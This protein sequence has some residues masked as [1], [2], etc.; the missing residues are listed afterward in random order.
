[1]LPKTKKRYEVKSFADLK[2]IPKYKYDVN[3]AFTPLKE[4]LDHYYLTPEVQCGL[5]GCHQW[6]NDGLIVELENGDITNVGHICGAAF[7]DKFLKAHKEYTDKILRP[8]AINDIYEAKNYLAPVALKLSAI[9]DELTAIVHRRVAFKKSF[10]AIS[11]ELTRRLNTGNLRVFESIQRSIVEINEM[12]AMNPYQNK[13]QLAFKE[14]DLGVLRGLVVFSGDIYQ[15]YVINLVRSTHDLINFEISQSVSTTE[16]IKWQSW[17]RSYDDLY[18]DAEDVL[19][20]A[21]EFYS[22]DNLALIA[23]LSAPESEKRLFDKFDVKML[24]G[25]LNQARSLQDLSITNG[26]PKLNRKERRQ[27]QFG[28]VDLHGKVSNKDFKNRL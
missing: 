7:G 24:D 9:G 25:S 11:T 17:V 1:M 5:K 10:P 18:A 14:V 23:K 20:K 2:L 26:K 21:K 19:L 15:K 22:P 8:Q 13:N 16:L 27:L 6:H 12:L 28:S 4:I 3:P